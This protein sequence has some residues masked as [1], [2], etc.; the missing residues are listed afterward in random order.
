[1]HH[2]KGTE[3]EVDRAGIETSILQRSLQRN[4][5]TFGPIVPIP[6]CRQTGL[7]GSG[8]GDTNPGGREDADFV[9]GTEK[10]TLIHELNFE[11]VLL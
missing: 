1:M 10:Y 3:R 8:Q 5:L 7:S 4:H 9:G 11:A 2:A 6:A